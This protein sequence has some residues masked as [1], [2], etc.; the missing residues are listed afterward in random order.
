[1]LFRQKALCTE[2]LISMY[3]IFTS[4]N[5]HENY[6]FKNKNI[7]IMSLFAFT[8]TYQSPNGNSVVK[9]KRLQYKVNEKKINKKVGKY[10]SKAIR[11]FPSTMSRSCCCCRVTTYL[12]FTAY[13]CC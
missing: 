8:T 6:F 11:V 4:E 2:L 9:T 3:N 5:Q 10:N 12:G 7:K 13:F 1:M